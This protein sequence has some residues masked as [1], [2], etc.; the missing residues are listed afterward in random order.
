MNGRE[1]GP[2]QRAG[3]E[4]GECG[5]GEHEQC[6]GPLSISLIILIKQL[7]RGRE[8]ACTKRPPL[9]GNEKWRAE[10]GEPLI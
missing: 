4:E 3:G 2:E 9:C 5:C 8:P 7:R 10:V 6:G 1:K